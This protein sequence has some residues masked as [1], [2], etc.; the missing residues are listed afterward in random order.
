MKA[1]LQICGFNRAEVSN[2]IVFEE[3][4]THVYFRN[5]YSIRCS[6]CYGNRR[7]AVVRVYQLP[8][9]WLK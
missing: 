8:E 6:D 9:K 1:C 3:T 4:S 5:K 2:P 7:L